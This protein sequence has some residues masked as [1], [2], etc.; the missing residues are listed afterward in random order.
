MAK[1]LSKFRLR[2]RLSQ[3]KNGAL[4]SLQL[5]IKPCAKIFWAFLVILLLNLI[6]LKAPLWKAI[7]FSSGL[8]YGQSHSLKF[9]MC[10]CRLSSQRIWIIG[11]H[12]VQPVH[13][14]S[15]AKNW[16]DHSMTST[17]TVHL[18]LFYSIG[19]EMVGTESQLSLSLFCLQVT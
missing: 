1:T 19:F 15:V 16:D 10:L 3:K 5:C 6:N 2:T 18:S 8:L 7:P 13:N 9:G 17:P 11:F 12:S 4:R 14:S